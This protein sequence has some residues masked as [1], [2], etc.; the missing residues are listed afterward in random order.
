MKRPSARCR[1]LLREMSRYL[2][3][4]LSTARRRSIEAHINSCTCCGAMEARLRTV[5]AACRAEQQKTLPRAVRARAAERIRT[6]VPAGRQR[7]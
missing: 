4:E 6:L 3:G 7:V 2:D 1:A 5:I